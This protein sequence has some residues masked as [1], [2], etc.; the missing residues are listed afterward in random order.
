[1]ADM[2]LDGVESKSLFAQVQFYIVQSEGLEGDSAREVRILT[3]GISVK[4]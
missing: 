4:D 1:M 3:L 2:D